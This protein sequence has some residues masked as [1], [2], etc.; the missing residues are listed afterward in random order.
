MDINSYVTTMQ[1]K[2]VTEGGVEE[3]WDTYIDTLKQMGYDDF[4]K[5]QMDAFETYQANAK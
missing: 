1:A 5:I 3:E 4:M 2:W